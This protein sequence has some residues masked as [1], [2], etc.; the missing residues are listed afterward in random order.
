MNRQK[1]SPPEIKGGTSQSPMTYSLLA[2]HYALH[3]EGAG[4]EPSEGAIFTMSEGGDTIEVLRDKGEGE[5]ARASMSGE[6][7]PVYSLK[8]GGVAVPTGRV[9]VRFKEG[10]SV[11]ERHSAIEQAGYTVA[12]VLDYA[13][14]AAWLR[15]HSGNISDALN[16][17][18]SLKDIPDVENVEPQMLMRRAAR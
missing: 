10:V 14:H 15:T 16:G 8:G 11:E 13:P 4:V 5:S 6:V 18:Q 12:Q 2:D 17:L 1:D 7:G 3:R 9:L